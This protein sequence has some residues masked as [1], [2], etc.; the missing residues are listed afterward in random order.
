MPKSVLI[1]NVLPREAV[2]MI[3]KE[4]SV[5]LNDTDQPLPKAE[6]IRRLKGKDALICH[7]IKIGRAHV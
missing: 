4:I 1:S 7:I 5:E 3:P 6:L 2:Q